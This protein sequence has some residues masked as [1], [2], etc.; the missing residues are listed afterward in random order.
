MCHTFAFLSLN[1]TAYVRRLLV[2]LVIVV[3]VVYTC[4]IVWDNDVLGLLETYAN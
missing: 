3:V 2:L 1:K 4:L